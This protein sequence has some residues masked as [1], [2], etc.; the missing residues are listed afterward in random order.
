MAEIESRTVNAITRA[1]SGRQPLRPLLAKA[2]MAALA[3]LLFSLSPGLA[4]ALAGAP[5]TISIGSA[6]DPNSVTIEPGT[7]VTWVNNDSERHRMAS[8]SGPER[9]DT[10][11]LDPGQSFTMTFELE[12]TYSYLDDR[13][14]ENSAYFG[15]ITVQSGA[16]STPP[17]GGGGGG[18]GPVSIDVGDRIY[19]PAS[20][21]VSPGTAITWRNIDSSPHTVT[22]RAGSFDSGIFDTGGTYTRTFDTPGTYQY[23]CTLHS[24][25]V[26]TVSVTGSGGE[27][28]PPPEPTPPPTTPPPPPPPPTTPGSVTIF[29]NG[30]TPASLSVSE[31]TTVTWTNTGAA[32]HT[33]TDRSG[34]FDSGF[35]MTGDSFS[36]TFT[37]AGTYQYFC[38]IHPEM[39][40]TITVTGA[41]GEAPPPP[42]PPPPATDPVPPQ[43]STVTPAP[44][45]IEI[46]DNAFSPSSRQISVGTTLVWTN[47]GALP[48]TA[49]DRA[50]RFDSGM[51]MSG[52]TYR[53]TFDAPG[54]YEY[55]CTLHPEMVG[56]IVVNS[57]DGAAPP[58]PPPAAPAP[59]RAPST[60]SGATAGSGDVRVVDNDYL[61]GTITVARGSTLTFA[62]TGALPHTIT[63]RAGSFDSGIVMP[64]QSYRRTF[65]TAGTYEY[66]CTIHPEM[67]GTV[68]V[69]ASGTPVG[70]AAAGDDGVADGTA[71]QSTTTTLAAATQTRPASASVDVIDNDFDPNP[72]RV[73]PGTTVAWTVVGDLPHTV[74]AEGFDSGIMSP[75]D[76]FEWT[77][78]E[79]G[80]F[81]YVCALHPGMEGTVI[82]EVAADGTAGDGDGVAAPGSPGSD[83]SSP[84]NSMAFGVF[85]AAG[86]AVAGVG[87]AVGVGRFTKAVDNG[88]IG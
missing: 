41:G 60:A 17:P 49:T 44:G 74:T 86:L 3:F 61:P 64:G 5:V 24:D 22:D 46:V 73:T 88:S 68:V 26:G 72:L 50:G 58:P 42:P 81:D 59:A 8:R 69:T 51:L 85:M 48:H 79:V 83:S 47:T 27:A 6:L 11:N 21:T 87:M 54:T 29:D 70:S 45:G 71:G 75:G 35:M 18:G 38:T 55:F 14:D 77:F 32:P 30:Y 31:G 80:T 12:G 28:P 57:S 78:E 66:F 10:G 23:F 19:L 7:T 34:R 82:V 9:F 39:V 25:M 15:T 16:P 84:G 67:S 37:T 36:Q 20:V 53:R 4:A 65:S 76:V 43:S 56:T 40:A 62:N 33:A 63:D 52:D 13:N 1:L 2:W